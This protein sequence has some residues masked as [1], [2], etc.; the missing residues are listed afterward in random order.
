MVL[1][2]LNR[3]LSIRADRQQRNEDP[4]ASETMM[5]VTAAIK[6]VKKE[7][8]E[9]QKTKQEERRSKKQEKAVA[10]LSM[11]IGNF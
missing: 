9:K 10:N 4:K 2:A 5:R 7:E 3:S 11:Q 8:T 1:G 6:E